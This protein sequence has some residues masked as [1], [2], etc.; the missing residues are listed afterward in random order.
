MNLVLTKTEMSDWVRR[1]RENLLTSPAQIDTEK[2]KFLL[3]VYRENEGKVPPVMLRAKLF[4]KL[5]SERTIFIDGNPLAGTFTKYNYGAYLQPEYSTKWLGIAANRDGKIRVSRQEAILT[6]EDKD[7]INECVDFFGDR[8][9]T[10]QTERIVRDHYGINVAEILKC[11]IVGEVI[12]SGFVV[13]CPDFSLALNKGLKGVIAQIEAE[14][15]KLDVF[16]AEDFDKW[17]WYNAAALCLDGLIILANRYAS[18]A[19]EMASKEANPDKKRILERMAE[20]CAWAPAN[21]ARNFYEAL[22]SFWFIHLAGWMENVYVT[23]TPPNTFVAD[24]YPFYKKD[25]V[26]GKL[27]DEEVTELIQFYFLKVNQLASPMS[28]HGKAQSQSRLSAHIMVGRLDAEGNNDCNEL[29]WLIL[30]AQR[31]IKLPEPTIGL[32]YHDKLP[33]DFLLKCVELIQTG[34][35]QPAFHDVEKAIPRMLMHGTGTLA[36]ARQF[37]LIGCNQS[38][39]PGCSSFLVT[40]GVLNVAKMVELAMNNGK[41]PLNGIQVGPK[42]GEAESFKTYGELYDAVLKQS[43]YFIHVCSRI[44]GVAGNVLRHNFPTPF[45]SA[46]THD[47]IEKGKDIAD[48][49]AKYTVGS[50]VVLMGAIDAG[51]SLAAVKKLV[52]EDKSVPMNQLKKALAAD[53]EGHE[54]IHRKCLNAPKHGNDDEYIDS[55]T[56]GLYDALYA[57]YDKNDKD[58]LGRHNQAEAFSVSQHFSLGRFTGAMPNGRNARKAL[59]DASVSAQPGT[60]KNGP[61]AL[62]KSAAYVIDTIKFGTNHFNVKVLPSVLKDTESKRKFLALIRTYFDLG[63]YHIQFNCVDRETLLAAQANPLEH[64]DL[65]VRVAGFSAFFVTLDAEVQDEIIR[66]TEYNT[67]AG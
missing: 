44:G 61:T 47:C 35:G 67:F 13:S 22:Q 31:Q 5:C 12:P 39:S 21:P 56:K 7:W 6:E 4:H 55:I 28:V 18:L 15:A 1:E 41:D 60:D 19:K 9:T 37:G 66:R 36:N 32:V 25:K 54:D 20:A 46:L 29:D 2:T 38:A 57:I 10:A 50:G 45:I 34:I 64:R 59:T 43:E 58:Y 14:K 11:G 63:G 53:W 65:V 24:L 62:A 26:E 51:N 16:K 48:G 8:T 52:F 27:T 49:G 42:T 33:E 23:A 30:E 17:H 40:A 3:Q